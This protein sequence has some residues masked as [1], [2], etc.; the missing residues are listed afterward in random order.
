MR[1]I[2]TDLPEVLIIEPKVHGDARGF[3][4]EMYSEQRYRD[5]GVIENFVQDN[6]SSSAKNVIRGLHYQ[7]KHPQAKLVSVLQGK[8]FDVIVDIRQ[9]SPRFGQWVGVELSDETH[10]QVYVPAGFAHGFCTL[11]DKVLF[12]YNCS[13]YYHPEDEYGI[14]WNDGDINIAWPV[15]EEAIIS[16]KD[17]KLKALKEIPLQQLP[18]YS[19]AK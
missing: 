18:I 16:D 14:H 7:L 13:D 4:M 5:A 9:G 1:V 12:H 8:V 17:N 10:R 2:A 19:M 11:S 15:K 6:L 3:F